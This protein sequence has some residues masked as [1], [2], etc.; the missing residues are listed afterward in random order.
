[1]RSMGQS[2]RRMASK[3]DLESSQLG[4]REGF[5]RKLLLPTEHA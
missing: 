2:E 5:P 1:M 4:G 3:G